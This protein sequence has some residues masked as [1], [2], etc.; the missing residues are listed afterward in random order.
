MSTNRRRVFA[1]LFVVL[2]LTATMPVGA[3]SGGSP[4][5]THSATTNGDVSVDHPPVL[6]KARAVQTVGDLSASSRQLESAKRLALDRLNGSLAA[7]RDPVRVEDFRA[8]VND[9]IAVAALS[10][11]E[12]TDQADGARNA[13]A[14]ILAANNRTAHRIVRDGRRAL[15]RVE[16]NVSHGAE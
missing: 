15:K 16:G 14:L 11:F 2:T 5:S 7:H 13:T 9:S 10:Q 8:I 1:I 6:L 12:R 4:G 3:V